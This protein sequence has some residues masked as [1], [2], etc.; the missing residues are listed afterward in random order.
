[1]KN[2]IK[3]YGVL[4]E[5]KR[6]KMIRHSDLNWVSHGTS[7]YIRFYINAAANSAMWQLHLRHDFYNTVFKFKPILD[8]ASQSATPQTQP[9]TKNS[10]CPSVSWYL[11]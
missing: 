3:T 6:T 4:D 5:I 9:P 11:I 1:M 10:G 2:K 7:S 8:I